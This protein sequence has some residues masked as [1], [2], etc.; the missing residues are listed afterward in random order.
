[1]ITIIIKDGLSASVRA[2]IDNHQAELAHKI[3]LLTLHEIV[4]R[5][6]KLADHIRVSIVY[7]AVATHTYI[8]EYID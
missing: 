5:L 4:A 7:I 6:E 8:T 3:G 2:E 1:M